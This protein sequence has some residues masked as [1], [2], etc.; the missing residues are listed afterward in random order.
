MG[1]SLWRKHCCYTEIKNLTSA[2]C[3]SYK[4]TWE[5][6]VCMILTGKRRLGADIWPKT[7]QQG[8]KTKNIMRTM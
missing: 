7:L 6:M 5:V 3:S 1:Y 2:A 4:H 8:K